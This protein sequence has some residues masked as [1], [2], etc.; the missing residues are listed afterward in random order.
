M[1]LGLP[2]FPASFSLFLSPGA[3]CLVPATIRLSLIGQSIDFKRPEFDWKLCRNQL[4]STGIGRNLVATAIKSNQ[5]QSNRSEIDGKLDWA[6]RFQ[7]PRITSHDAPISPSSSNSS[8][9]SL[10]NSVERWRSHHS[11]VRPSNQLHCATSMRNPWRI[12]PEGGGFPGRNSPI[13]PWPSSCVT[14]YPTSPVYPTSPAYPTSPGA[15][16]IEIWLKLTGTWTTSLESIPVSTRK[17][18]LSPSPSAPP[19]PPSLFHWAVYPP[20]YRSQL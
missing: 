5:W 12:H 1:A 16:S 11:I 15:E 3:C 9:Y 7:P 8:R 6:D 19:P 18:L 20:I 4:E 10:D 13:F 2:P 17:I 14:T